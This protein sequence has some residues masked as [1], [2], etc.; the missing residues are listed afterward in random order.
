MALMVTLSATVLRA[1]PAQKPVK[2]QRAPLERPSNS[3]GALTAD[4]VILTMRPNLR[5]IIPSTVAF[6]I[7][8]ALNLLSSM[9]EIQSSLSQ[10]RK[11]PGGGPP[12]LLTKMSG[13]G[14]TA[15]V[16]LRPSSVVISAI[17]VVTIAPVS[18]RMSFAV[19]SRFPW[20]VQ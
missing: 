4:A 11:P 18:L 10:L 13:L 12:A 20:C 6:I 9:A 1:S 5:P 8:M 16:S 17:T 19:A 14:Q 3:I 15:K 7:N 2:P